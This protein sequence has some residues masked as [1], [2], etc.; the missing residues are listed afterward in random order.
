M[1]DLAAWLRARATQPEAQERADA[2][3][4]ARWS[5]GRPKW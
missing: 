5:F 2:Q 4:S 3:V 1:A